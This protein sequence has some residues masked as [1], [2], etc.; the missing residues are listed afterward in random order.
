[1]TIIQ[2]TPDGYI[3]LS[4][5]APEQGRKYALEDIAAG[6]TAQNNAFHALVQEFFRSGCHSYTCASWQELKDFIKRDMG[7]GY[8]KYFVATPDGAKKTST[9]EEAVALLKSYGI[10]DIKKYCFGNLKS[11]SEYTKNER[12]KTM[13]L[14]ISTMMQAGVNTK[15]F[16]EILEGMEKGGNSA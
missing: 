6:T 15:K 12:K 13:D 7:V 5:D 8:D 10:T 11:W 4:G 2:I 1:L 14:L 16:H 9:S 3:V